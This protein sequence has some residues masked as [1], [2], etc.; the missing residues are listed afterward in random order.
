MAAALSGRVSVGSHAGSDE[1]AAAFAG[2]STDSRATLC[3]P[4][5]ANADLTL[6]AV[7]RSERSV[8]DGSREYSADAGV[9]FE[10]WSADVGGGYS[11]DEQL[12]AGTL[13]DAAPGSDHDARV[14]AALSTTALETLPMKLSYESVWSER[15]E[16]DVAIESSRS[17]QVEF[18]AAGA[19][20]TVGLEAGAALRYEDDF[21]EERETLG[22]G[23][24]IAVRVPVAGSVA[25]QATVIPNLNRSEDAV[26]RLVSRSIEYGLGP[27]WAIT[28][29][30]QAELLFSRVDA[31]ADGTNV[32]YAAYQATWKAGS[33]VA[34][35]P[36]EG[37]Y[38]RA[39]YGVA[40]TV[41]GNLTQDVS[42]P[43][44]WRS[45]D[46]VVREISGSASAS[47]A[48]SETGDPV[49]DAVDWGLAIVAL[50]ATEMTIESDYSGGYLR[51]ES[52]ERVRH[53]ADAS[54]VHS[55]SPFLEYRAAMTLSNDEPPEADGVWEHGYEAGVTLAP[56][57]NRKRYV[58]GLS[59]NLA[60]ETNRTRNTVLS[61]AALRGAV[62]VAAGVGARGAA[63]WEWMN[64]T[65]PGGV[66]GNQYRYTAGFSITEDG[67]PF[68]LDTGYTFS[69]GYRG[70]RHE[71]SSQF[72][73]PIAGDFGMDGLLSFSSYEDGGDVVT[74]VVFTLELVYEF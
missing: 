55:P 67:A 38:G 6:N 40:K 34:Y 61:T 21:A 31:W 5:A 11:A 14:H 72:F 8:D 2:L 32:D 59:E 15:E 53:Q 33:S 22:A 69:H 66:P 58:V 12:S 43:A 27:A 44:G 23:A 19:A 9:T 1:N 4:L 49:R 10:R 17:D 60:V 37:L 70:W 29:V 30:L 28:D 51:E 20:G 7:A 56:E 52:G 71:V 57:G 73:V 25:V 63:A 42:L 3:S 26:S 24:D 18:A 39:S 68:S 65:E 16:A 41:G 50:P 13:P 46:G 47:T 48:R 45:D 62:P 36:P 74:P 54:F 64:Q 35:E